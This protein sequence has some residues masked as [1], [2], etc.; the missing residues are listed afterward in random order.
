LLWLWAVIVLAT[1]ACFAVTASAAGLAWKA[2]SA[3]ILVAAVSQQLDGVGTVMDREVAAT[4]LSATL[5]PGMT[6]VVA[7]FAKKLKVT[8]Y[9]WLLLLVC[10]AWGLLVA[11]GPMALPAV[12]AVA[13]LTLVDVILLVSRLREPDPSVPHRQP[14]TRASAARA[15]S[16]AKTPNWVWE[17]AA[18]DPRVARWTA[19]SV[20]LQWNPSLVAGLTSPAARSAV[21]RILAALFNVPLWADLLDVVAVVLASTL[22]VL[23][24]L[25]LLASMAD[26]A[27]SQM[28]SSDALFQLLT[29]AGVPGHIT[30]LAMVLLAG[31]FTM[32][33]TSL[34]QE[35]CLGPQRPMTI[36]REVFLGRMC[37]AACILSLS[38]AVYTF[39][40]YATWLGPTCSSGFA[41]APAFS[42]LARVKCCPVGISSGGQRFVIPWLL[43][44]GWSWWH[45]RV[46]PFGPNTGRSTRNVRD[47]LHLLG[48]DLTAGAVRALVTASGQLPEGTVWDVE[49]AA[50]LTALVRARPKSSAA[51]SAA[52][53]I[54]S[55]LV[56]LGGDLQKLVWSFQGTP[57]TLNPRNS[58]FVA[59]AAR[60]VGDAVSG[61]LPCSALVRLRLKRAEG[62]A[63]K[64]IKL[65][66]GAA[67]RSEAFL[68]EMRGTVPAERFAAFVLARRA[69]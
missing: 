56:G 52:S 17:R 67:E 50:Q 36:R 10:F 46:W 57:T 9:S 22:G 37:V 55:M 62:A 51:A 54:S 29:A 14:P 44:V 65:V 34:W 21:A 40:L 4:A 25:L 6:A 49:V 63:S 24:P 31:M 3:D 30:E 20:A 15:A 41:D 1:P 47:A 23:F 64:L 13:C 61:V 45:D 68:G 27:L 16:L 59:A 19:R 43:L 42:R 38:V 28:R 35:L 69:P 11:A 32:G 60:L 39:G 12:L 48:T 53:A 8:E 7:G 5:L 26:T 66:P 58:S 2:L 33:T 18:R